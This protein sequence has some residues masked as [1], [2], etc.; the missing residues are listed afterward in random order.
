MATEQ[1]E[2]LVISSI[3]FEHGGVI[4]VQYTC[5]GS[6]V[7]PPLHIKNIPHGTQSLA[8]IAEDPDTSKGVFDHWL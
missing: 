7:N 4:P 2:A 3:A 1:R 6:G 8:I 5:E